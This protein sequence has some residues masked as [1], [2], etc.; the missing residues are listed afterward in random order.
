MKKLFSA[1]L[2]FSAIAFT[3]NVNAQ[4]CDEIV[5][6]HVNYDRAK[7]EQMPQD[8][9]QWYCNFSR[10]SFFVTNDVPAGSVVHDIRDVVYKRTGAKVGEGFVVD[11]AN[12][13]YYAYNFSEFQYQNYEKTIYFH[14]PGST[15]NY[16]GLY[17][18]NETHSR[19]NATVRQKE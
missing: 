2:L 17:S 19:V 16:L 3:L 13:S 12:L 5:L 8:K 11:L 9:V 10:N 4:N 6:P 18:I 7:L 14:T 15:Y 1:I